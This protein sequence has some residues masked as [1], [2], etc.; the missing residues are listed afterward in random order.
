MVG[1]DAART[2]TRSNFWGPQM[3][4]R[5]LSLLGF[6]ALI[7]ASVF[8]VSALGKKNHDQPAFRAFAIFEVPGQ[9]YLLMNAAKKRDYQLPGGHVD[10]ADFEAVGVKNDYAELTL[11]D[12]VK[13]A[14]HALLREIREETGL[15]LEK[16]LPPSEARSKDKESKQKGKERDGDAPKGSLEYLWDVTEMVR[17]KSKHN[18]H[19][20]LRFYFHVVL[21]Q[22]ALIVPEEEHSSS[23]R[24]DSHSHKASAAQG[25]EDGDEVGNDE[26]GSHSGK[27]SSHGE[28]SQRSSREMKLHLSSEHKGWRFESNIDRAS[29]DVLHHSGGHSAMALTFYKQLRI[30]HTMLTE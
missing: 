28:G 4:H 1:T 27:G 7:V 6:W 20:P 9:G 3:K 18:H 29:K 17:E 25:P 19:V 14:R 24:G 30:K 16:Y 8:F 15:K 22:E 13:V 11:V 5:E 2:P 23:P 12:L 26:K 10:D 21:D